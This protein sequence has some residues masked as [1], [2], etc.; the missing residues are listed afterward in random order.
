M[1]A[2]VLYSQRSFFQIHLQ[3]MHW[4]NKKDKIKN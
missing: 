3:F 1:S 4:N 2:Y